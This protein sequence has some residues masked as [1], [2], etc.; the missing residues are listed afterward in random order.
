[1]KRASAGA[2]FLVVLIDLLGFGIVL[3]LLPRYAHKFQAAD[4]EIGLLMASYSAMQFLFSPIW[5]RVSDRVGRRPILL[6]GLAGSVI[7]YTLFAFADTMTLLFVSRIAAGIF[8]AT[9]GTAHAYIADVTPKEKRGREMALIGV[10]F[11][12]GFTVGPAIGGLTYSEAHPGT[13]GFVAAGLSLIALIL[14]AA[15]LKEPEKHR[16]RAQKPWL[17]SHG[18]KTALGMKTIPL[19]LGLNFVATFAFAGLESTLSRFTEDA[20]SYD[21]RENGWLFTYVGFCML[22]AQGFVV[23]RYMMRVGELNFVRAG[24]V[25]LAAG[26]LLTGF[27]ASN[28]WLAFAGLAIAVLGFAMIGP[29]LSSLLSQRTSAETQG[30]VLG[31]NQSGLSMARI[32]GPYVGLSLFGWQVHA[33]FVFS[34]SVMGVAFL[35]ALTLARQKTGAPPAA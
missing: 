13:P 19:I 23:R 28:A 21:I 33:P 1:M 25:I 6:L 11:G 14:A 9:I 35:G 31:V 27:S 2:V 5:G 8:G 26:L 7:S 34:A 29:S 32:L 3:P 12:V 17:D 10:A 20:L 22:M 18:L 24:P 16:F 30:E 4:Y 15:R